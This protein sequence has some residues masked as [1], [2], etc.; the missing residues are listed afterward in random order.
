MFTAAIAMSLAGALISLLRG[1]HYIYADEAAGAA[2]P[3]A[4]AAAA[5]NGSHNLT[6]NG[7]HNGAGGKN[8]I[9][10]GSGG[11]PPGPRGRI[12]A[13]HTDETPI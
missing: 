5:G 13:R 8:V 9:P 7:G 6:A 4:V 12:P 10:N 1:R 11:L 3:V 2:V